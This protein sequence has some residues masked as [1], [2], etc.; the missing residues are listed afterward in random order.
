MARDCRVPRPVGSQPSGPVSTTLD[1]WS[2]RL[3]SSLEA[4]GSTHLSP[5][6]WPPGSVPG[7]PSRR[8]GGAQPRSREMERDY[9]SRKGWASVPE[10]WADYLRGSDAC[11]ELPLKD[12]VVITLQWLER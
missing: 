12:C 7:W 3:P 5:S 2:R 1:R 6:A 10:R 4:A 11:E 9:G 8:R